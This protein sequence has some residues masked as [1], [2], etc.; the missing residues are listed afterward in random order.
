MECKNAD[1]INGCENSSEFYKQI[2]RICLRI[3]ESMNQLFSIQFPKDSTDFI[4]FLRKITGLEVKIE[5]FLLSTAVENKIS[6][7][8]R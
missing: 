6:G 2:C 3:S 7:F 1:I 4:A 5:T 8:G